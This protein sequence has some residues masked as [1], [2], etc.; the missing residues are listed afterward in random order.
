MNSVAA[1]ITFDRAHFDPRRFCTLQHVL[2][3]HPLLGGPAVAELAV[4]RRAAAPADAPTGRVLTLFDLHADPGYRQLVSRVLDAL[5]PAVE[6]CDPGM[7][8]R[9]AWILL[10]PPRAIAPLHVDT[11]HNLLL[12]VSGGNRLHVWDRRGRQAPSAAAPSR[13]VRQPIVWDE[14]FRASAQLVE[15]LPG[16]GAYLPAG[17]PHMVESGSVPALSVNFSFRTR[18]SVRD[19]ELI[20]LHRQLNT[21]GIRLPEPERAPRVDELLFRSAGALQRVQRR[22]RAFLGQ[23]SPPDWPAFAPIGH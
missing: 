6:A 14:A 13:R 22:F 1:P 18:G 2:D 15:L 23:P 7:H 3:R 19:S 9:A 5:Q 20:R 8:Y 21:V 12:Q 4:R 11:Q 16:S 17:V 10:A